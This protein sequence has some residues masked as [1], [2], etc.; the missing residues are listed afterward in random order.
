LQDDPGPLACS[1]G[2]LQLGRHRCTAGTQD[3]L[4]GPLLAL[5][6]SSAYVLVQ[7]AATLLRLARAGAG[8][9][10]ASLQRAR[11]PPFSS[12]LVQS[13]LRST[14]DVARAGAL[15]DD[16][17][18]Q[19][20]GGG[21]ELRAQLRAFLDAQASSTATALERRIDALLWWY[22]TLWLPLVLA[23]CVIWALSRGGQG[24]GRGEAASREERLPEQGGVEGGGAGGTSIKPRR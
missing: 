13:L 6:R 16:F 19:L 12:P 21:D 14:S 7:V 8:L 24:K 3:V 2:A 5:L 18:A 10:G 1:L 9:L 15:L 17:L 20:P 22:R 4:R 23:L 11:T